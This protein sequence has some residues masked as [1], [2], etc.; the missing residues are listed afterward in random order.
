MFRIKDIIGLMLLMQIINFHVLLAYSRIAKL[1]I[2]F[3]DKNYVNIDDTSPIKMLILEKILDSIPEP[4][5]YFLVIISALS[6]MIIM[7]MNGYIKIF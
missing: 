5:L 7:I 4:K 2:E 6:S 3:F 1:N